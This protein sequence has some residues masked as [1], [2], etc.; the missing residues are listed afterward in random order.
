MTLS[1][2]T[3]HQLS[4]AVLVDW[5]KETKDPVAE[6]DAIYAE[7]EKTMGKY[8]GEEMARTMRKVKEMLVGWW[9][10][11]RDDIREALVTHMEEKER[12]DE[13][14]TR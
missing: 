12:K 13:C 6:F 1:T 10:W 2:L 8:P 5:A 11:H 7:Y 4:E 9:A 14:R 3:L